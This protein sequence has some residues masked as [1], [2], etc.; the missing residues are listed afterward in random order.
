METIR[1]AGE[2]IRGETMAADRW[3]EQ[4]RGRGGYAQH[5]W[6]VIVSLAVMVSVVLP[7]SMPLSASTPHAPQAALPKP[8]D[9]S[10]QGWERDTVVV[11]W[12]DE[13]PDETEWRVERNI[14]GAGWSQVAT[15]PTDTGQ[16]RD[17]GADVSTQNRQY[18]VRSFRSGDSANSPYSDVCNNRR[19]YENGPFRIFYGLR[20][21]GDD[22]PLI[23]TNEACTGNVSFVDL[24]GQS[25]QGARAGF[26]R[27]GFTRDAGVPFGSLD[28]IPI[29]VVWCDGGGCAGGGGLGLSPTLIE[30]SFDRA[31]RLGDPAAYIVAEHE[32]FHFLQGH[33]GGLSEPN[34]RWV[35]EGQA[36]STQD[37]ICLGADRPSAWC[38]DDIDTGYAG[39]VPE[40]NGYLNNPNV[41]IRLASYGAALFWTYL[42]EKYG[43]SAPTDQTEGGMNLMVKFWEDSAA[44]PGRD[45]VTVLNSALSTLG[46]STN[47]K[48]IFK[49]F[50]I[51]NVA[52]DLHG[53]GVPTKYQYA[54]M[55]QPGGD[56]G[57]VMYTISQTL[58]LNGSFLDTDE[59][60]NPWGA[61]YYQVRPASDVPVIPIKITQDTLTPLYYVVLGIKGDT[62]AYEQRY[63]QRNLDVTLLNDAYE[64]VVV[65]VAGLDNL[66]NYRIA[67]NGT[68]P[69]LRILSPTTG[70]KARVGAPGA[71]EKFLTQIEVVAGDG[72]PLAGINLNS[73]SFQ[74]GS[75]VVPTSNIVASSIIQGQQWFVIQAVTQ[76]SA[77]AYDLTAR[78][79]TILTGTQSQ[80]I[81]YIPR[82]DADNVL[83]IDK[84]GSMGNFSKMDSAKQAGRLYVDSWR[85]GDKIAV[86]S[87]NG[88]PSVDLTLRDWTDT[89]GGGSRLQ[90]FNTITGFVALGSTAIGDA[91]LAGWDELKA[92]GAGTH[93]WALIL[94]SDGM[95]TAG[96]KTFDDAI[97]AIVNSTD[98]KPVIHTVAVG[99][100][101]DRLRMQNAANATG[102]TYQY[103]S[104]PAD[105]SMLTPS[106]P[107]D[108]VTMMP[109]NLD[110][111]Y[112][113]I[114]A[115]VLG[116]QQFFSQFGPVDPQARI[117][118]TPILVDGNAS[119]MVISV[120]WLPTMYAVQ[121]TDPLSNTVPIFESDLRHTVWRVPTPTQGTWRLIVYGDNQVGTGTTL[122]PYFVHGSLKSQ[123]ML[124]AFVDTPLPDR[125]PGAPEHI[126]ALLTDNTAILGASITAEVTRPDGSV[127]TITLR[128]D[129][130]HGDGAANDGVYGQNFYNTG[131][132]GSYNVLVKAN[133]VSPLAGAFH[134][135]ALLS[136]DLK[137]THSDTDQDRLPDE[138]EGQFPCV[139]LGKYD[140]D[141]DPDHDGLPNYQEYVRGTNPCNPDTDGD[142]EADGTDKLPTEPDS[143][144]I[145]PPWSVVW[146]GIGRAWLKY[147]TLPTY[148]R[149]EIYRRSISPTLARVVAFSPTAVEA[150]DQ[151]IGTDEPP[152]GVFTDTTPVNNQTY[153]YYA[154]AVAQ[155]GQRST[156]L[157]PTCTTPKADPVPPHG[158]LNIN[159][160]ATSTPGPK[161]TLNLFA[162]DTIDPHND[163][164]YG[165]SYMTPPADS[166]SGVVEMMINQRSDMQGGVWE[167]YATTKAWTLNQST[168]LA[169]VF[170]KYRDAAGNESEVYAATIHVGAGSPGLHVIYLP[171]IRR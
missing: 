170:V 78:Y 84:S 149:V 83:V 65:I 14:G 20:G 91:L 141:A 8:K 160:G 93:D 109:L 89:P 131:L 26:S 162:S 104:A 71:P 112:R 56:Y 29:N 81:N 171:L 118:I 103:V 127:N 166:A 43:T 47:Y 125:L 94:L 115:N 128:D 138:W 4:K 27:V 143:G 167:P 154:V 121:L 169:S 36:R 55:A 68:Q 63:E 40:V 156:A 5:L 133:G 114:A 96:T 142:G 51:A 147:V 136:F 76:T 57:Q 77:I 13:A 28:K 32:L 152:T 105:P 53:P 151:L 168:G 99:P 31:T 79:S 7:P 70:N 34:D 75:R 161:V 24:Q 16:W 64:R 45:A 135:E 60:V 146:P 9:I 148:Q 80:A 88:T 35:I 98:K 137:G 163:G 52:K 122:P 61:K 23:G 140:P 21:T 33:Y 15:L 18:R 164:E 165:A 17:T 119:E 73:F 132:A 39:Y 37:K 72:T 50:V 120:S 2:S 134:R 107:N 58:A 144:R 41:S 46:F 25:L 19:I 74:I 108:D 3:S 12:A 11:S 101:A 159:G 59:T 150:D 124:N 145:R 42:T 158:G 155:D 110:S 95:E 123:V 87:F 54:D 86:E 82:T 10:C 38:F 130:T 116:H 113:A 117:E 153:C 157:S 69:V 129:G 44:T 85:T 67:L 49:D 30:M 111:K 48:A 102:G 92:R 22:C 139:I 6:R 126:L 90:A 66:G 106:M 1:R 100:D 62:I 97:N